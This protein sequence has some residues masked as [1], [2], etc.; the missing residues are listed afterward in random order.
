MKSGQDS[1]AQ[2]PS[3]SVRAFEGP[4][5]DNTDDRIYIRPE[6]RFER[7][8]SLARGAVKVSSRC[9]PIWDYNSSIDG[10]A[11]ADD[12]P[13]RSQARFRTQARPDRPG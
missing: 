3:D 9:R 12:D 5:S 4:T 6:A 7:T 11:R 1:R 13:F 10:Q 2:I 8:A